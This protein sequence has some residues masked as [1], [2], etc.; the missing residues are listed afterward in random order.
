LKNGNGS[1]ERRVMSAPKRVSRN[2][3]HSP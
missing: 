1:I 3:A 2:S